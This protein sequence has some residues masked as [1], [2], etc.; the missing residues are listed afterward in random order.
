MIAA[1][2]AVR[3]QQKEFVELTGLFNV[4]VSPSTEAKQMRGKQ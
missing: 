4:D 3:V 1:L 2:G